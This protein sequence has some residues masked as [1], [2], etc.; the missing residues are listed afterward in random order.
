[1]NIILENSLGA[2]GEVVKIVTTANSQEDNLRLLELASNAK[3]R[4]I[5]IIAFCMGAMGRM[6]RIF[7]LLSGG[8]ISFTSL[9]AGEKSAPGQ[10]PVK[11]MK[12]LL[13][14]FSD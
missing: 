13:E 4:D 12:Q 2:K 8:Y 5:R 1:M 6:S 3:K 9:E 11:E 14:Y 10:I 7:S